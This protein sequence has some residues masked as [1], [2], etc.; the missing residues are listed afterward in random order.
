[1]F[2][3]WTP[4]QQQQQQQPG[5]AMD[6]FYTMEYGT[7]EEEE[8]EEGDACVHLNKITKKINLHNYLGFYNDIKWL[9]YFEINYILCY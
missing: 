2:L 5:E 9:F 6:L 1:M 8:E 4:I 7:E 3:R